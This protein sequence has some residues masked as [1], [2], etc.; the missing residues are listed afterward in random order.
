M[1]LNQVSQGKLFSNYLYVV[2]QTHLAQMQT[3]SRDILKQ[4]D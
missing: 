4:V 1:L 2:G 3:Q